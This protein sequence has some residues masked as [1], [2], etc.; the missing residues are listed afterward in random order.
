[1]PGWLI[2]RVARQL[3]AAVA[4]GAALFFLQRWLGDVF[5]GGVG[6]RVVGVGL[7]VGTGAAL[8]FGIAWVIGGIDREDFKTLLRRS[9]ALAEE[10]A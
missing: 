6:E 8:Y 5:T 7:I 9:P 3:L 1:M 10:Q 2:S 4:M